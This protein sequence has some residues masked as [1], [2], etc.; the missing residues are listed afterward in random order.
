MATRPILYSCNAIV[1]DIVMVLFN[2]F[3]LLFGCNCCI[4]SLWL[5]E[6]SEPDMSRN[7]R[8]VRDDPAISLSQLVTNN[9]IHQTDTIKHTITDRIN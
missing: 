5:A 1:I 2:E 3:A 7:E 6:S 4:E 9:N 8:D